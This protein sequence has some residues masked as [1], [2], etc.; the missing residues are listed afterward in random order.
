MLEEPGSPIELASA[1]VLRWPTYRSK[2]WAVTFLDSARANANIV[3]IIGV[4]SAVRPGV[5]SSDLDMLVVCTDP[6]LVTSSR[7]LEVDL[8]AYSAAEIDS[9]LATGHDMLVWAVMFGRALF[10]RHSFWDDLV[11]SWRHRLPLPSS[12]LARTR[13]AAAYRRMTNLLELGDVDAVREQ[14]ISYLTHLTRAELLEAGVYPASRPE[15]PE[16]LREIGDYNLALRLD[17]MSQD[18]SAEIF[19]TSDLLGPTLT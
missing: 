16:Q 17:G 14:A 5:S 1:E 3:A 9:K 2:D 11:E 18:D 12:T 4:G 19:Q 7:P 10:Q 13:A 6:S 8:R 15:L